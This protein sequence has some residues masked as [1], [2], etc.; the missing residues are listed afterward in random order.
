MGLATQAAIGDDR[1]THRLFALACSLSGISLPLFTTTA[2]TD[3]CTQHG[4]EQEAVFH[5]LHTATNPRYQ[6]RSAFTRG[7]IHGHI[8]LEASM[9][10]SL[11]D[12]LKR[13][14]GTR[15]QNL[16][17]THI[18][19][20]EWQNLLTIRDSD[21]TPII[22][23]W[24]L[25][26]RGLYKGDLAFVSSMQDWQGVSVLLVPRIAYSDDCQ[27]SSKRKKSAIRPPPRLF[28]PI[29]VPNYS[30]IQPV[31]L[32]EHIYQFGPLRLE[33]GLLRRSFDFHSI[34]Q[35][36]LHM[37]S[38][39]FF[40]FHESK[41]SEVLTAKFPCPLEFE[42]EANELVMVLPTDKPG[43]II[44]VQQYGLE[45]ELL[46]GE[47]NVHVSW[48][49]A[50]KHMVQGDCVEI[51]SGSHQGHQG[52]ITAVEESSVTVTEFK[53]TLDPTS[54]TM[55]VDFSFHHPACTLY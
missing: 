17:Y 2:H 14:P 20:E 19:R 8:Y 22:G 5:L 53:R 3:S 13:T 24:V 32:S 54:R 40:A 29:M 9:N 21:A 34:S 31:W 1:E 7:S 49:N 4:I 18:P 43:R 26:S 12:L 11:V 44:A 35:G 42:F 30:R 47:G 39:V 10:S 27:P 15:C 36:V 37:P 38:E 6:L 16:Q 55:K 52:F 51:L 41:H 33:N 48:A 25:I 50:R 45:V 23:E 46:N 28:D